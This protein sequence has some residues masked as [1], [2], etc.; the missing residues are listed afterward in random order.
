[1]LRPLLVSTDFSGHD[2]IRVADTRR[3]SGER[4]KECPPAHARNLLLTF[5]TAP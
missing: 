5:V 4:N 2:G 3:R 1:M